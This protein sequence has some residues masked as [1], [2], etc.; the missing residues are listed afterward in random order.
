MK[1]KSMIIGI[2]VLATM[3]LAFIGYPV[4]WHATLALINNFL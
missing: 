4:W 1:G 3:V 2:I